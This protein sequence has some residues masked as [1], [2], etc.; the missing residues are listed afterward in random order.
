MMYRDIQGH[1][2]K[3]HTILIALTTANCTAIQKADLQASCRS[4]W[5]RGADVRPYA[6]SLHCRAHEGQVDQ[7]PVHAH[8]LAVSSSSALAS[9][10]YNI[11]E[12]PE[13]PEKFS[14]V[15]TLRTTCPEKVTGYRR[16]QITREVASVKFISKEDAFKELK[17]TLKNSPYVLEGLMITLP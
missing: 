6:S 8:D 10:F 7:P 12:A 16:G 17:S 4:C 13:L 14:M 11:N 3:R 1:P 2:C 15:S 5:G 9:S